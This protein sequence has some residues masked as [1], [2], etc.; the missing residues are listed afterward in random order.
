MHS[1]I[2]LSCVSCGLYF[3]RRARLRDYSCSDL[4]LVLRLKVTANFHRE[5]AIGVGISLFILKEKMVDLESLRRECL[6]RVIQCMVDL[7]AQSRVRRDSSYLCLGCIAIVVR[8][9]IA[10]L[11]CG[12]WQAKNS[13]GVI[14]IAQ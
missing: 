2:A 11:I 7:G 4:W 3:T 10:S 13:S 6:L 1:G 9:I 14:S 5:R 12:L 8:Q